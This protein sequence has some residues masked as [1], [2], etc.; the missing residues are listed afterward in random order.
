MKRPLA[1]MSNVVITQRCFPDP[2][3]ARPT[4][5]QL[6]LGKGRCR[7]GFSISVSRLEPKWP[8]GIL[9]PHCHL[10][11]LRRSRSMVSCSARRCRHCA[12]PPTSEICNSDSQRSSIC[13]SS[14]FQPF[15]SGNVRSPLLTP[16][17]NC[18]AH[19]TCSNPRCCTYLSRRIPTQ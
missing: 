10:P 3:F 5:W 17:A 19:G 1:V 18:A 12:M 11:D 16:S 2:L 14:T 15:S 6:P 13:K 9:W 8:R 7:A 4:E